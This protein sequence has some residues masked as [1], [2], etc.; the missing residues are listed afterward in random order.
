MRWVAAASV[1]SLELH[2]GFATTWPRL[3]LTP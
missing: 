1:A 2:P 3:T